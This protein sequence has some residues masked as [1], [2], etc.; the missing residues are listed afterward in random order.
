MKVKHLMTP[1]K[2][3]TRLHKALA[4]EGYGSRR[5]IESWIKAGKI[6][7]NGKVAQ[8]GQAISSKDRIFVDGKKVEFKQIESDVPRVLLYNKPEGEICSH[9]TEDGKRSVF[10][11]LPELEQ[12][13][14]VMVGRLDVNSSGLLLFTNVGELAHRLMHPRFNHE[15]E[16]AVR[17]LGKVSEA[18]INRMKKGVELPEG[19]CRFKDIVPNLTKEGANQWYTVTLTEGKYREVRQIFDSQGNTVSR[20]IRTKYAN[21][22]LPRTLKKGCWQ[23]LPLGRVN[24]LLGVK[25][26]KTARTMKP[27][28]PKKKT[29][30]HN[31]KQ[32][33]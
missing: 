18:A 30:Y 11:S 28:A 9:A 25:S 16:Y 8:I 24:E 33:A 5:T 31:P 15:R 19:I 23:E 20:L 26:V 29:V 12:G 1:N 3:L 7:V 4:N 32:R 22:P 27:G 2:T 21:I 13:R 10:E 17:V 6:S 14:W